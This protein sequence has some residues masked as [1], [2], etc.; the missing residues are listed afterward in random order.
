MVLIDE[1]IECDAQF[2]HAQV[3]IQTDSPFFQGVGVPSYV[4]LEYM[5]QS[6][7]AWSGFQQN[8]TNVLP[9]IGF[10]LG[11]RQLKLFCNAFKQGETLDIFGQLNY[12]EGEIAAFYC[13]IEKNQK[14]VA[15]GALTVFQPQSDQKLE[16]L[17]LA[18]RGEH[19]YQ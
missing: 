7:A 6:I 19:G 8:H 15:E 12:F 10:L 9:R 4:A 1:L 14:R 11:S 16:Q 13:W 18:L 3:T 5:A 17:K 2:V